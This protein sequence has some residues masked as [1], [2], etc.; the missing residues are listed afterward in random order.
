MSSHSLTAPTADES[1]GG[2][3]GA[4]AWEALLIFAAGM[5]AF[6][7]GLPSEFIGLRE[8]HRRLARRW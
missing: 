6:T 7:V 1:R 2:R 8:D 4:R 5:A 3:C